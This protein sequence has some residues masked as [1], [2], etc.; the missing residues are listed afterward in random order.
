MC[1]QQAPAVL[2][3]HVPLQSGLEEV[4]ERGGDRDHGAEHDRL[5]DRQVV[6]LVQGNERNEDRCR[7]SEE[8][9]LPGLP[10]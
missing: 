6:L 9:A 2:D 4:A 3:L 1:G 10:G 5:P 8:E 7:G